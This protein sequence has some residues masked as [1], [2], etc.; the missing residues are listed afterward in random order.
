MTSFHKTM[1]ACTNTRVSWFCRRSKLGF[2]C[3]FILTP[4][5][6]PQRWSPPQ[7]KRSAICAA[8]ADILVTWY[9]AIRDAAMSRLSTASGRLAVPPLPTCALEWWCPLWR[10]PDGALHTKN[11]P[12][13]QPLPLQPNNGSTIADTLNHASGSSI[14]PFVL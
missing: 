10:P 5:T 12:G 2:P 4:C 13:H 14:F 11:P 1:Y 6:A 8:D 7:R 9:L 3:D